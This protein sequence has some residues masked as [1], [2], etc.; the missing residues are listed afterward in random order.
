MNDIANNSTT[1]AV[2]FIIWTLQRTG[3][4][5]L[6]QRLVDRS[7][8]ICVQHEPFNAGRMY[9][10]ITQQWL[11]SH[12]Q[13]ALVKDVQEIADQRVLIK[14]C[15]E[16]VPWEISLALADATIHSGY[17]HLFLYRKNARDRLLSLHF[18]RETG[19]WG[20]KMNKEADD[21]TEIQAIAVDNLIAHEHK[22]IGLLQRVW[23]HLISQ[24][25]HPLALS[26][27]E[28]YRVKPEQAIETLL[29]ILKALGLSQN[30]N[31]DSAFAME[32]IG[33]GD[34]GTRDQY[35]SIPGINEL[36]NALQHTP[37]FNPVIDE[38]VLDIKTEI[39]PEWILK[40]QVD[41]V[42]HSLMVGQSLELG[43]VVVLSPDAPKKLMLYLEY[44]GNES[45]IAWGKPSQKMANLFPTNPQAAKA[46]F[47]TDKFCIA[48]NNRISIYL[49][50]NT[51]KHYVLFAL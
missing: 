24:G 44:N 32:V 30:E 11:A 17:Q 20:P 23:Q 31:N 4:T 38:V 33:K 48:K 45:V 28:I 35:Q 36:E 21:N 39:L 15:V 12:D 10:H 14:H 3:G 16:T 1:K 25:V 18:A 9:G 27:E 34:Q 6:T 22:S 49:K 37:F 41:I 19:V 46:R 13:S 8:L 40:A 26:Y 29:P 50:D 51:G 47:K 7:D 2:P 43:G 42:P 5:N